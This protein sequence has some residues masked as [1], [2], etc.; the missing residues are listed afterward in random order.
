MLQ[1]VQDPLDQRVGESAVPTPFQRPGHDPAQ[2]GLGHLARGE[3][4][5]RPREVSGGAIGQRGPQ[6]G[7]AQVHEHTQLG[8]GGQAGQQSAD[9]CRAVVVRRR[10]E[11]LEL[12]DAYDKLGCVVLL[13]DS[14]YQGAWAGR[15]RRPARSA[16]WRRRTGVTPG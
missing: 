3:Q 10:D 2:L 14:R 8:T 7:I 16:G 1:V 13:Q 12:I 11:F 6:Q 9:E 5:P 15:G 4:Q